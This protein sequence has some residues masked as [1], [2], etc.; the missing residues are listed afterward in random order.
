MKYKVLVID[1][2][3]GIRKLIT[4]L[5]SKK[6]EVIFTETVND[7]YSAITSYN[8]DIIIIDPLFPKKE[9]T[10]FI[11]S[12]RKWSDCPIIAVSANGTENAAVTSIE[13][14]ADDFI[15]KPFFSSEFTARIGICAKRISKLNAA[16]GIP[17]TTLYLNDEL[18]VDYESNS[19]FLNDKRIHL[20]KNEFKI[21]SLL[22]R[23]AGKVLS[24]DFILKS[25]WGPRTDSNTGILRVNI[26]NLRRK[27]ESNSEYP[28]YLFTENGIG[29]RVAE[30]E[31][32][33]Q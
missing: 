5:L 12:V 7:G 14:G 3:R 20:T 15:R 25:V 22:C 28:K 1:P 18:K 24:N 26:T 29:Y 4:G 10:E 16:K 9:G 8:P 33:K 11:R 6:Y 30:N 23:H 27:L 31:Y 17:L 19:V 2:D 21:L 13:A 32:A